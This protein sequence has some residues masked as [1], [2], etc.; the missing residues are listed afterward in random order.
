ML[1]RVSAQQ[2]SEVERLV[3]TAV[4]LFEPM[5]LLVMGGVVMTMYDSR[6]NLARQVIDEVK[7]H[8]PD[9]VFQT[10]IPRSVRLS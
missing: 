9:K 5:M 3:T 7:Q 1:A 4:R 8:L 2:E 10:V 6:T